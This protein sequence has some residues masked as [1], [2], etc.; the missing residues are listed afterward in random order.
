MVLQALA[1]GALAG[2]EVEAG[3]RDV[4][5]LTTNGATLRDPE[6]NMFQ[7]GP[8]ESR[9]A[10]RLEGRGSERSGE[11]GVGLD[12]EAEFPAEVVVEPENDATDAVWVLAPVVAYWIRQ[13][14]SPW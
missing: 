4:D 3:A 7:S 10:S 8:G 9:P 6:S 13:S 11:E 12:L 5:A 1:D 14:G 2:R